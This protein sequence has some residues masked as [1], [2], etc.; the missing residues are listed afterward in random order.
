MIERGRKAVHP[1]FYVKEAIDALGLTQSEF[2]AR[3][4]LSTKNASTLIN[5]ESNV[6]FEVAT[7]LAA[8]FGNSIEGWINL[9][10]KYDIYCNEAKIE[11]GYENDWAVAKTIDKGFAKDLLGVEISAKSK[12][13]SIDGLRASLNVGAL[14]NLRH[15]DMYAFCKSS[16]QKDAD[17]K[18]IALCNA[19]ISVAE[20]EARELSCATFDKEA[21]SQSKK[22]LRSLTLMP[23]EEFMPILK[24][25]LSKA[26]VKLVILPFLPGSNVSGVTKWIPS[27]ECV[28]VAANDCG[29]VADRIWFT[30]C[31]ELGHAVQ[32]H[33]RHLTI[34]YLSGGTQDKAE[35]EADEFAKAMLLDPYPYE[36]FLMR[37]DFS[38]AAIRRFASE[39][40]VAP[41]I[42]IGRLQKEGFIPWNRFQKEKI[43]YEV[44]RC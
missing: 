21:I 17:E 10:T 12:R 15:P 27:E 1:G 3:S 19:W 39:Q 18:T 30:I 16:V 5:G 6:T 22:L 35:K 11:Q 20:R 24:G 25:A 9:Q 43:K 36:L 26:G 41:F 7:K 29:K 2:A 4:G 33:K 38:L 14:A 37:G 8:F 28:M 40:G 32:N 42:V 13:E 44:V 23:P 31:H 34:S